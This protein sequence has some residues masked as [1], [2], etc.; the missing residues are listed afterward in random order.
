M[1]DNK[2]HVHSTFDL[3]HLWS[4][5]AIYWSWNFWSCCALKIKYMKKFY[6]TRTI[7]DSKHLKTILWNYFD[8]LWSKVIIFWA[9]RISQ[10][11]FIALSWV[12]EN[13][14]NLEAFVQEDWLR[15]FV[16]YIYAR[17]RSW[18]LSYWCA[19]SRWVVSHKWIMQNLRT[20]R[21]V[22]WLI[23]KE[24]RIQYT[25]IDLIN[26]WKNEWVSEWCFRP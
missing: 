17:Y 5:R 18:N 9:W 26:K 14:Q 12:P 20:S 16:E 25:L 3:D 8:R 1:V 2:N 19:S 13:L 4:I 6:F 21:Y 11:C 7:T 22:S 15:Y 23:Y 24:T 10:F